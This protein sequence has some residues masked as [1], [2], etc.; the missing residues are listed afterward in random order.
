MRQDIPASIAFAVHPGKAGLPPGELRVGVRIW[1]GVPQEI[2]EKPMY[3][4]QSPESTATKNSRALGA[5][6][7]VLS[8]HPGY[9]SDAG[10]PVH[11]LEEC[12]NREYTG[13]DGPVPLVPFLSMGSSDGRFLQPMGASVFG[14]SPE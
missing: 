13:D 11:V 12:L 1:V 14:F 6:L 9:E 7:R 2:P 3:L 10:E 8:F 5:Q 4:Q